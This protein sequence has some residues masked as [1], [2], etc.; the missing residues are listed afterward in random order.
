VSLPAE[1]APVLGDFADAVR[2]VTG[3]IGLYVGGSLA[4]G[5][6]HAGVSDMDLAAVIDAPLRGSQL[7]A[8]RE[9]H[10]T[11][12]SSHRL[13]EKLHCV[14]VPHG[15]MSDVMAAHLTW[16]HQQ[17]FQRPFTGVARAELLRHGFALF[18]PSPA[19]VIP[20]VTDDELA[21]AARR[22][23]SGY[24]QAALGRRTIWLQDTYVDLGL[25]TLA[26]VEATL[27]HGRL[28][29]KHEAMDRLAHFQVPPRLI[30]EIQR[31]REGEHVPTTP[32]YR[33]RRARLVR[34]LVAEG[35]RSLLQEL[36]AG[37][38]AP[39]RNHRSAGANREHSQ[40][41]C[42]Q[43][44]H[45]S[46]TLDE[47]AY[48]ADLV[49]RWV[50]PTPQYAWPLLGAIFGAQVWVKHE[51]HTPTGAFKVRGGL[52]YADRLR[53]R[54]P[55]V[56][57]IV[58]AT[59]GNHGQSLAFAGRARDLSVVIVVPHGNSPDKNALMR[60][61][62]AEVIEHGRDFQ[63]AREYSIE[64]AAERDL[65]AVPPYHP[66]LVLGVATYARELFDAIRELDAVYVPVG[67]GSG[68][69][70]L[71]GVRDLLGLHTNIIGVVSERAAATALSFEAGTVVTTESADTF[72]DGVAT[73]VPDPTAVETINAGAARILQVSEDA[74]AEAMR[75][76]FTTTHN[77]AEPAGAIALAGLL[78]EREQAQGRR[79]GLIQTGGNVDADMLATVLAGETP[80]VEP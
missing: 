42:W 20:P 26:R 8:V 46:F 40:A 41:S 73:R 45:M 27:A 3:A 58:S 66:D 74:A 6:F 31:R 49:R 72:I 25:L 69:C 38:P 34:T 19:E 2:P 36:P 50:P 65:E 55:K 54:R 57:G 17:L 15:S 13:A 68:I 75:L 1:V 9:L 63:A 61:F 53:T 59:R 14:Y 39:L 30:G 4:T 24:W 76:M 52:V 43:T 23:L 48:A 18:G 21:A 70:G 51:N 44:S 78:M 64:L 77:V 16:T 33:L 80:A 7:K 62:G 5:D 28:I 79:I 67:M 35:I 37:R 11:V 12:I 32:T 10:R 22:E 56:T 47:L 60:G 29:T 71:I